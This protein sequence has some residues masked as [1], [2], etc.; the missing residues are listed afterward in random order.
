[1]TESQNFSIY[2][3]TDPHKY[4]TDTPWYPVE[5]ICPCDQKSSNITG[6][7]YTPCTFG[8]QYETPNTINLSKKANLKKQTGALV[9]T[10][11]QNN[12]YVPPQLEPRQL[13][14]IGNQ[15]RSGN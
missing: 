1:M 11:Y 7:G 10:L 5:N 4:K 12:Q 6:R 14:R 2:R 8:V 9:G 13:T 15:W 3:C